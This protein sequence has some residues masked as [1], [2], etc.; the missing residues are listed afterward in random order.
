MPPTDA[1]PA[2]AERSNEGQI[3]Q[4]GSNLE[5]ITNF[6]QYQQWR[7]NTSAHGGTTM[8]SE[9]G[10][11]N[12]DV[13]E[14]A[15]GAGGSNDGTNASN[16]T[17]AGE[18]GA[19]IHEGNPDG[20]A[21]ED[22]EG[23]SDGAN[24]QGSREH[25][26]TEQRIIQPGPAGSQ[27]LPGHDSPRDNGDGNRGSEGTNPRPSDRPPGVSPAGAGSSAP[28]LRRSNWNF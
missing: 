22:N 18:G 7:D 26:P 19:G 28:P 24:S 2:I 8:P 10:N 12:F 20:P 11:G 6:E 4:G 9:F 25:S 1:S 13:I 27:N 23:A 17:N 14:S 15:T 21:R 3:T 5:P 16:G